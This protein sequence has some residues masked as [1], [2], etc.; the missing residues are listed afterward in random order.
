MSK[1]TKK[2]YFIEDNPEKAKAVAFG[3]IKKI[4]FINPYLFSKETIKLNKKL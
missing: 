2:N 1:K 4:D 3:D